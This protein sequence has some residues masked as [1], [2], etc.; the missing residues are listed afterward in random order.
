MNKY[1]FT[2]VLNMALRTAIV[3]G[4]DGIVI[5]SMLQV[6]WPSG[7]SSVDY[8]KDGISGVCDWEGSWF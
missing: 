1:I 5:G 6:K 4:P 7:K 2:T 8:V 3:G